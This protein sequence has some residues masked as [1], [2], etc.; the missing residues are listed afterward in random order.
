MHRHLF[1]AATILAVAQVL[2]L[3]S[4][5]QAR[6][7]EQTVRAATEVVHEFLD[8]RIKDIPASLLA[9]A[10]GVAVI[11]N[12]IKVGF[13]L[14]GQRGK[15]VVVVREA[16][17]SWRAPTFV[18]LTGGSLGW[19]A[20]ASS[21]DIVLV[22]KTRQSVEGLMDG[23]F[24][25]G[26]DAAVAAG[27]I[28][29]RA[30]AA[31]D[32]ELKAEI[33]SY[34]RSRGLFAGLSIDGSALQ[35]DDR[36]N[37]DYYGFVGPDGAARPVPASALKLV[38]LVANITATPDGVAA[39]GP[40][41]G[42]AIEPTP[43][44]E[45]IPTPTVDLGPDFL[46]PLSQPRNQPARQASPQPPTEAEALRIETSRAAGALN[47]LLDDSWRRYLA[48][49]VEVYRGGQPSPAAIAGALKRYDGVAADPQYRAL[50]ERPE[51]QTTHA[52]LRAYLDALTA[53]R[54][55]QLVLPPPP[56]QR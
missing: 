1:A 37:A 13:V 25:L 50:S 29:R 46:P 19:Q 2:L 9:D 20:G 6:S 4:S 15:G 26:A 45:P 11:P 24:K 42:P 47:P 27:P 41:I 14:G 51:F 34:S 56:G 28:G 36:A 55:P 39:F 30:E 52:L 35:I 40:P 8:L 22:F 38:E 21:S 43:V 16:D 49:P 33:Y 44:P 18:T 54:N 17:G 12:V 53:S 31:T 23:N 48:M 10:H 5:A 32:S 3:S 7:E